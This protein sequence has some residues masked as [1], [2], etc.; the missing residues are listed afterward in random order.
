METTRLKNKIHSL[1]ENSD[2]EMLQSV[3]QILQETDY[4]DEFKNV[5][6][7]EFASYQK[8]KKVITQTTMNTFIE[9]VMKSR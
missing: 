5:L 1:I 7:E 2:E 4:T 9:Q 8:D 3:Y 6:N